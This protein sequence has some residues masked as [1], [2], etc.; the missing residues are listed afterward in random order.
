ME[1]LNLTDITGGTPKVIM[2][3]ADLLRRIMVHDWRRLLSIKITE[4]K[5]IHLLSTYFKFKAV[6]AS[7]L[8][9]KLIY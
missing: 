9:E 7:M 8:F 3:I 4:A 2:T 6:K 1:T 5:I